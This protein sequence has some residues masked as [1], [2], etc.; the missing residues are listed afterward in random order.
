MRAKVALAW[1]S[2]TVVTIT[3]TMPVPHAGEFG[4][5][6]NTEAFQ[7]ITFIQVTGIAVADYF[8]KPH[9]PCCRTLDHQGGISPALTD[10]AHRTAV[11]WE[12][13]TE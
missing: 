12:Q 9:A 5:N 4:D 11:P 3:S 2:I 7:E 13:W 6:G 8:A 1:R 10:K